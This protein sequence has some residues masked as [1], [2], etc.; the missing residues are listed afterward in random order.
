MKKTISVFSVI[1]LLCTTLFCS[2]LS[3]LVFSIDFESAEPIEPYAA[4]EVIVEGNG[5]YLLSSFTAPEDGYYLFEALGMKYKKLFLSTEYSFYEPVITLYD[6]DKNE[7]QYAEFDDYKPKLSENAPYAKIVQKLK[8][9][10]IC[11]LKT[12]LLNPDNSGKYLIRAMKAPDFV[13]TYIPNDEDSGWYELYNY[14]GSS[15]ELVISNKFTVGL[16]DSLLASPFENVPLQVIGLNSFE[17]NEYLENL[18]ISDKIY[19]I[20]SEAFLNCKNLKEVKIGK[21]IRTIGYKAF[22]GCESLKTITIESDDI[23]LEYQCLGYDANGQ[24][25]DDFTIICNKGSTAE[26]YAKTNN[27]ETIIIQNDP[28][29]TEKT[30]KTNPSTNSTPASENKKTTSS[31]KTNQETKKPKVKKAV[32]KKVSKTSK[33]K[34][35]KVKWKRLSNVSGYQIKCGLNKKMTKGKKV[36]LTKTNRKSKVIKGLK[37]K[38]KYYIK[39]RAYKTYKS[40][41]GKTLRSYGKWSK[42]KKLTTK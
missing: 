32:I 3:F 29:S 10:E 39:I 2:S 31:N 41:N 18:T 4:Y 35:L 26:A 33:K 23:N 5:D 19:Y 25:C 17:G 28:V 15:K 11:Y 7:L 40:D 1:S 37:P 27:I 8:K 21:D 13:F 6:S 42:I 38:R 20:A 16:E 9:G 36:I 34:Q 24:K 12:N 22:A 14:N 30:S